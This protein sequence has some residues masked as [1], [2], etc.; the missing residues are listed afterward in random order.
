M[1]VCEIP[2][3][4]THNVS[5]VLAALAVGLVRGCSQEGMRRAVRSF[6]GLPHVC[7]FVRE[8][9]GVTFINDSKG[10]NVD[11]TLKA[12]DSLRQPFVIILGGQDKG[13]TEFG[14]LKGALESGVKHCIVLGE[15]A[16]AIT[17][18]IT[19]VGPTS[20]VSSLAEGVALAADLAAPGDVVLFSPA[21]ASFDMFRDY[22]DR[23]QQ[24]RDLVNAL[25]D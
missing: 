11:A 4:G 21:C 23:G 20:R 14:R 15:S 17:R 13:G 6:Q 2:L 25:A 5:N 1:P 22:R 3:P 19:G 9:R 7:E 12:I 16:E 8:R 24:F 10:T 18:A